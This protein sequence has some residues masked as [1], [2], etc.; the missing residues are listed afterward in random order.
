MSTDPQENSKRQQII[1]AAYKVFYESGFHAAG[2]DRLLANTGISKRTLYKHFRSKEELIAATISHYQ[3]ETFN[4]LAAELGKRAKDP[5]QK[6]LE[7][8]RLKKEA[9]EQGDFTGCFATNA[10][11]EFEGKHPIIEQSCTTYVR[12]VE[13][14]IGALCQEAKIPNPKA[15]ASKLVMLLQGAIVYTQSSHNP[16]AIDNALALAKDILGKT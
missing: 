8:F 14:Y 13:G 11:L 6:I 5:K 1:A 4:A 10:K 2:V 7:I 16:K 12:S 9:F 15:A 3:Q